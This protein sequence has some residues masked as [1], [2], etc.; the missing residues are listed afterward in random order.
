MLSKEN[1]KSIYVESGRKLNNCKKQAQLNAQFRG[2]KEDVDV[3]RGVF[4]QK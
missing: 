4:S 1:N 3:W 2:I